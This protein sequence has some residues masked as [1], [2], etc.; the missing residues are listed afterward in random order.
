MN[1][2]TITATGTYSGRSTT[3]RA[4][5]RKSEKL[6]VYLLKSTSARRRPPLA[7]AWLATIG[8]NLNLRRAGATS[9]R[10]KTAG[11]VQLIQQQRQQIMPMSMLTTQNN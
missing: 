1:T 3:V 7:A 4:T 2:V 8:L 10:L 11:T 9:S 6:A 5:L